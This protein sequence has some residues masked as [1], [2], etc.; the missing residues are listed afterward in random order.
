MKKLF[1]AVLALGALASCQKENTPSQVESESKTIEISV[2]NL[3]DES[4]AVVGGDTAQGTKKLCA[5]FGEL[6]ILFVEADGTILAEGFH[7]GQVHR[8]FAK[9]DIHGTLGKP[10]E[11]DVIM[12]VAKTSGAGE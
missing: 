1:V 2:L 9:V 11:D 8:Q 5:E 7:F 12:L 4:R 3:V 6:K 10:G